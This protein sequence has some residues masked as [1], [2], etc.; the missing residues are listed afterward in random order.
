MKPKI[1]LIITCL[2]LYIKD[3]QG[4]PQLEVAFPN[5]N[6]NAP[7]ELQPPSDGT[8]R[9]FVVEQA[10]IIKVFENDPLISNYNVF[11]D[12]SSQVVYNGERGLLGLAFHPDYA[13]NG[14]FYI[15]YSIGNPNRTRISRFSVSS[16][17]PDSADESSES[18]IL[19]ISQPASNHNGGRES[20]ADATPYNQNPTSTGQLE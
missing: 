9:I 18:V 12:I 1:F 13:S 5:L 14:Y 19:D 15:Y 3:F 8:D 2:I 16:T 7:V 6:F 10:G 20:D 17:N 4:Q 11:L